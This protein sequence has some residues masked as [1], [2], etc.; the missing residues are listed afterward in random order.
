MIKINKGN[1]PREF[2]EA[3]KNHN[4]YDELYKN[5]KDKLKAILLK[6]QNNRCDSE[7]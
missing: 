6:E 4:H 2:Y 3:K 1:V 5:E 7:S